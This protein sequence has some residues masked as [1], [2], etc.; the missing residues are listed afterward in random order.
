[1]TMPTFP[2]TRFM[3]SKRRL[4]ADIVQAAGRSRFDVVV[5]AFAGSGCVSHHFKANGYEVH[6]NDVLA[7]CHQWTLASV[8]NAQTRLGPDDV[9]TLLTST[10]F[11]GSFVQDTFAD[12]YFDDDDNLLLDSFS[13]HV[14]GLPDRYERAI[15]YAAMTRACLKRRPRG[16][17][18]YV[19]QRYDDG[20]AD[21]RKSLAEHFRES[22][23]LWNAAVFDNGRS[24]TA[25]RGSALELAIDRPALW[26]L[27]PPYFGLKS[28]NDYTRRYHFI[29]GL[30]SY[31]KDL[32]IQH[33]TVTKKFRSPYRDFQTRA[34]AYASF[35]TLFETH[36]R[37]DL[38]ISY[39]SNSLPT[40]DE[41]L[42]MLRAAGRTVD[43][44][45]VDHRYSFGTHG[46]K[47]ANA[48]NQVQ[49]YLFFSPAK[50]PA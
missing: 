10:A 4:L 41:M 16:V 29:E 13:Y 37:D 12:L 9:E 42:E 14:A 27:D 34:A 15:A 33:E 25:H 20:R 7:F 39:S 18:T 19:G 38:L 8:E 26:Y 2:D 3:G 47:L 11:A 32:D 48:S 31:W 35:R 1:M 30:V 23:E 44:V 24:N 21:L 50:S 36:D 49:E 22:V 46:H 40:K 6:S 5:D 17:F 28:D 45:E 43:V